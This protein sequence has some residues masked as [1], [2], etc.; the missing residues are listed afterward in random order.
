MTASPTSMSLLIREQI[1]RDIVEAPSGQTAS[2]TDA[3][4][5]RVATAIGRGDE[6]AFRALYERYHQRLFRFAL[7]LGRG[8]ESLAHEIVQSVFVIAAKKLR[9]ADGEAHLWNWLARVARQQLAKKWRTHLRDAAIISVEELP[10]NYPAAAD[11]DSVLEE[12]LDAA[13]NAMEAEERQLIEAFYFD[14]LSQKEL[15]ERLGTT[16]KAVSSRLERAREKLRAA[17]KR[18]L[19]Y[20]S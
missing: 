17:I 10:E 5:R 19:S 2:A 20:E 6:A 9:R 18:K 12:I 14:N 7:V 1:P 13:L 15:A 4:A 11:V 8:D 16:P 3:E